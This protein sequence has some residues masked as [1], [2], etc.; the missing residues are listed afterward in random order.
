MKIRLILFSLFAILANFVSAQYSPV[1]WSFS[2]EKINEME[3]NVIFTAEIESGWYVYSQ[4]LD[5]GGPIPTSFN[6]TENQDIEMIGAITETGDH[7]K[8]NFDD[9]FEMQLIKYGEE[10]KF[11]QKI[12]LKKAVKSIDGYLTFMTCNNESCLPPKDVD[13]VFNLN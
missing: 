4:F 3:F 7:K 5:E 6:F 9:L 12:K 13:F 2:S 10:V 1:K 11:T 8:E